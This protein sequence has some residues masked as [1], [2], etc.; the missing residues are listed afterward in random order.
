VLRGIV[1]D[2]DGVIV[3]SHPAHRRAWQNFLLT[4]GK[5]VP[6]SE[7]NFILDGRKREEILRHFLGELSPQQL[8]EYGNRKNEMLCEARPEV[9]PI[10][11]AI[12]FLDMLSRANLKI[13]LATSATFERTTGTLERL[14][15]A[16]HFSVIVTGCDV[17]KGKPNPAIYELAARRLDAPPSDLLAFEDAVSGIQAAKSAGMKCLAVASNGRKETLLAAGA[18]DIVPN[19][20]GMSL[21]NLLSWWTRIEAKGESAAGHAR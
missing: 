6:E 14:G 11:G 19:F 8:L 9:P 13:A 1:F 18:D 7:L 17:E 12:Q 5:E 20:L 10:P 21:E 2:M 4:L 16:T 15:I 3:D